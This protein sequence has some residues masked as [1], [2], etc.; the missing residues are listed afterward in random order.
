MRNL[1]LSFFIFLFAISGNAQTK[2]SRIDA[3]TPEKL[4]SSYANI[5]AELDETMQQNFAIAMTTISVVL[6][7]RKDLGGSE[8]LK[9]IIDGKTATEIIAESRKLTGYV[10][11]NQK[12]IDA[13]SSK[14]FSESL[15]A[16]LLSL[17]DAKRADFS[18]AVAKLMYERERTKT[19]EA[20]F[21]K[22]ID[23]KSPDEIIEM[24][25]KIDIPFL[26]GSRRDYRDYKIERLSKEDMR[27]HGIK[28]ENSTQKKQQNFLDFNNSLVPTD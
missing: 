4:Q 16:V 28:T 1:F 10:K 21:L 12:F 25:K 15:G 18:E 22:S 2:Q 5:I 27:K 11:T 20:D 8:K 9:E 7:Q 19:S 26:A 13:S 6:T 17:P 23:G 24:A 3:S 14:N